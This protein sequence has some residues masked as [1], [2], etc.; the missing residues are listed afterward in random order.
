MEKK[1]VAQRPSQP[2]VKYLRELLQQANRDHATAISKGDCPVPDAV[3]AARKVI[4]GW[5]GSARRAFYA[6]QERRRAVLR[7]ALA[8]TQRAMLFSSPQDAL[9]AV[10]AFAARKF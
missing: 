2:Q 1:Q 10:D 3:K 4:K 5:E 8:D 6:K 7:S 9:K